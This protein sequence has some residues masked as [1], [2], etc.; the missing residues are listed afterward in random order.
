MVFDVS[1]GQ[2]APVFVVGAD[3]Q[4]AFHYV[5]PNYRVRVDP[6]VLMAAVRAAVR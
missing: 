6:A 4:I 1:L 5:N 3:G 2:I